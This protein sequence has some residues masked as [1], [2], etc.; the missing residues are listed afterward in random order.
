VLAVVLWI[1]LGISFILVIAVVMALGE[2]TDWR[3]PV[4]AYIWTVAFTPPLRRALNVQ[5]RKPVVLAGAAI[6]VLLGLVVWLPHA[7]WR[8][9]PRVVEAA[10]A[11]GHGALHL[12][13]LVV[14][15]LDGGA[16]SSQRTRGLR[17]GYVGLL[18]CYLV[19]NF[20]AGA[21]L[22][23]RLG[24]IWLCAIMAW[25]LWPIFVEAAGRMLRP[26]ADPDGVEVLSFARA[27][28]DRSTARPLLQQ[29]LT[30]YQGRI[31][32]IARPGAAEVYRTLRP[33]PHEEAVSRFGVRWIRFKG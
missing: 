6:R 33:A 7:L 25:L 32:G 12:D 13:G 22:L 2:L 16:K 9:V 18:A 14:A 24:G 11:D 19:A 8:F 26:E 28:R 1:L 3:A 15:V 27:T 10:R 17:C 29:W 23:D 21:V 30:P 31:R 5:W 20:C 4:V